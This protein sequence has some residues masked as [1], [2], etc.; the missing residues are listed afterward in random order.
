MA[1]RSDYKTDVGQV[2]Q[3]LIVFLTLIALIWLL[4]R[5]PVQSDGEEEIKPAAV[6]SAPRIHN[7]A[8]RRRER[9][10]LAHAGHG[11][12]KRGLHSKCTDV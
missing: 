12:G 3:H 4:T 8:K 9:K 7:K 11:A 5:I 1:G 2:T 10:L 6:T